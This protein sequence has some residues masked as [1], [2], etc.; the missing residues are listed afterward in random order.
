ML[1]K[2][3]KLVKENPNIP[4]KRMGRTMIVYC[5]TDAKN[6]NTNIYHM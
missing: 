5:S 1:A 2:K 4:T 3:G 6:D